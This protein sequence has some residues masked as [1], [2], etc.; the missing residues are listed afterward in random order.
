MS[1]TFWQMR[2]RKAK[3]LADEKERQAAKVAVEEKPK[4]SRKK[5]DKGGDEQ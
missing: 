5:A 3:R 4:K 1:M 2:R